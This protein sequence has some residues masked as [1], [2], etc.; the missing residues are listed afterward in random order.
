MRPRLI[1]D[2]QGQEVELEQ[3]IMATPHMLHQL[4]PRSRF[5][6]PRQLCYPDIKTFPNSITPEEGQE[7]MTEILHK[8][9][10][11]YGPE[12]QHAS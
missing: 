8:A 7:G 10:A 4:F 2:L 3:L 12:H 5:G 9:R 1:Y 11:V 6:D